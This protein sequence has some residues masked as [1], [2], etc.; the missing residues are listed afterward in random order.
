[1]KLPVLFV[2]HGNPMHALADNAYTR[3]LAGL[4]GR[5]GR[6]KAILAVSAHWMTEGTWLTHMERPKTIHD[7]YGFPKGLF[8]VRYPAP[9]SPTLAEK[10]KGAVAAPPLQLD[11]ETWGLDHGT[12]AVLRHMYPAADI[13]VVQLSVHVEQ[14]GAYHLELGRKLSYLRENGVLILGSGNVV[15]NLREMDWSAAA[16]PFAW[17]EAFDAH[18]ARAAEAGR[19][20]ALS[21][22]PRSMP[23]G[24]ESVP[25]PEH[26]Y[27]FLYALGAAAGD[28]VRWEYEG[29]E[30]A[31]ISMRCASFGLT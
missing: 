22:D 26:W 21:A 3:A 11:D 20:E 12:W 7:F 9:G 24:A 4:A 5:V 28:R 23:G 31:S 2:G 8:E 15:H 18:V 6:P 14:P 25:T 10:I 27:P 1:M 30:S 13:P 29:I 19:T 16:K 17:A